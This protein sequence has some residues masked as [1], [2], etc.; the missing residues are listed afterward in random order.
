MELALGPFLRP[1]VSTTLTKR[2]LYWILL[3]ALPVF[4]F[5][6]SPAST[7]GV[8]P[9]TF[10][11]RAKEPW[12]FPP[13]RGTVR[14]MGRSSRGEPEQK[15]LSCSQSTPSSMESWARSWDTLASGRPQPR[16]S[17]CRS[18]SVAFYQSLT[19]LVEVNQA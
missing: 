18:R 19:S 1:K 2:L 12:T 5:F 7:L 6:F 11:A 3:L 13:S 14:A 15:R 16:G 9:L 8:C 17:D 10:P 4:F